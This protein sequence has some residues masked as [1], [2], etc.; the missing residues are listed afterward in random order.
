M[1]GFYLKNQGLI[2]AVGNN[3][4]DNF[5]IIT[6][7]GGSSYPFVSFTFTNGTQTGNSGPSLSNLLASY[8]TT[9]NPWLTNTEFFN[10]SGGI[11]LWTVPSSG[12]YRIEA[13]GAGANARQGGNGARIRGDFDLTGGE[14]IRI[15][16]G[17]HPFPFNT[18][19][20]G[21]A[22]GS[23]VVR[24][25]YNTNESILVIAGGGGGG[26]NNGI[27]PN[28]HGRTFTSGGQGTNSGAGG[29]GGQGG[30]GQAGQGGAG[31]FGNGGVGTSSSGPVPQS[32]VN[33]GT[34]GVNSTNVGGFG[35]G[36]SHGNTH[37]GGGG[38]YSGGGGTNSSPWHG[39]G[40]GSYNNG[41]NQD[42][43]AG[44]R[45]GNGQIVITRL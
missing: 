44:V 2:G 40:G 37:G 7:L 6:G 14:I 20:G 25:P 9:A 16:V 36:G 39:G 24:T 27:Q 17:Q 8:D 33:G 4:F 13:W 21:A 42:N 23:F 15:L 43:E 30:V 5:Q 45:T 38:G 19:N 31:F 12:T 1:A 3:R 28:S 29:T 22:G 18:S 35:G 41:A 34:G 32:F 11:Q 26:H 10:E